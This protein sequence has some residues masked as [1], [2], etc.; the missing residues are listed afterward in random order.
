[1]KK[2]ILNRLTQ[3]STWVGFIL[4]LGVLFL[5]RGSLLVFACLLVA[6]DDKWIQSMVNRWAPALAKK[7][8]EW[9]K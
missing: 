8:E 9:S 7:I 5:S 1:M 2:Y 3:I 4:I 6:L